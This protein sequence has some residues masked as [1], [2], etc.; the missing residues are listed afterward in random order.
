MGG[1]RI[2]PPSTSAEPWRTNDLSKNRAPTWVTTF[3]TL[4]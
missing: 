2:L 1:L 4:G 3:S